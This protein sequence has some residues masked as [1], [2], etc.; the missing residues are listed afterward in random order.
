MKEYFP[1]VGDDT[2]REVCHQ[3]QK[4]LLKST[5]VIGRIIIILKAAGDPLEMNLA[6]C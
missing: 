4:L 1:R 2:E 5:A 3:P 6:P